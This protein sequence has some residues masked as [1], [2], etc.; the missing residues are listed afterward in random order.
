MIPF[1]NF[2][3]QSQTSIG[4]YMD[5]PV[6]T[7]FPCSQ[8]YIR[9]FQLPHPS[10]KTSGE[11]LFYPWESQNKS[12]INSTVQI[13]NKYFNLQVFFLNYCKINLF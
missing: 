13:Y 12:L 3:L 8:E 1:F 4:L 7:T 9:H 6:I 11:L 5:K 2:I 10:R